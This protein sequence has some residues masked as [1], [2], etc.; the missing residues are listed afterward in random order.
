MLEQEKQLQVVDSVDLASRWSRFWAA[1]IDGVITLAY[2]IPLMWYTDFGDRIAS[3]GVMLPEES[4]AYMIYCFAMYLLIHGYLLHTKGQTIGKFVFDIAIVDQNGQ[5]LGLPKLFAKRI[6]PISIS[7]FIPLIGSFLP[8][9]DV[10]FIFRKD[11]RCVHDL[12]AGTQVINT[13]KVKND[14]AE[15]SEEF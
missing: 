14:Q 2:V 1:I 5:L 7:T 11:K 4:F 12:I 6:V 3:S 15:Y 8:T 13:V 9:V 10:L